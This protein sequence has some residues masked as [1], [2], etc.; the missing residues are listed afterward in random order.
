MDT[1]LHDNAPDILSVYNVIREL[2]AT[3]PAPK[4]RRTFVSTTGDSLLVP[5]SPHVMAARR[6]ARI[7]ETI[8][9]EVQAGL[10]DWLSLNLPRIVQS[11]IR[12]ADQQ[13]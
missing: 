5:P 7:E 3:L 4:R 13:N 10:D 1:A 6:A 9:K 8:R 2:T 12:R 11:A